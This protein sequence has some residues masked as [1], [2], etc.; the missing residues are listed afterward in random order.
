MIAILLLALIACTGSPAA[1][2]PSTTP[3][4]PPPT[5]SPVKPATGSPTREPVVWLAPMAAPAGAADFMDLFN[6]TA[7][8]EQAAGHVQVFQLSGEWVAQNATDDELRRIVADLERRGLV[9]AL[10]AR[11][12]VQTNRC[13]KGREGFAGPAERLRMLRRL[14]AAG[15]TGRLV[16]F[17]VLDAPYAFGHNDEGRAACG[18]S[19]RRIA[20]QVAAYLTTTRH[21]FSDVQVGDVEP[22]GLD[23][24]IKDLESW[25]KTYEKV[26]G[27][28]LAFFHLAVDAT[29]SGWSEKATEMEKFCRARGIPFGIVYMGRGPT[30]QAW[31]TSAEE[32]FVSF[33]A[34]AG[35]RPDD[36]VFQA[37]PGRP[38]HVLPES[39]SGTLTHLID[40]YFRTRTALD[41]ELGPSEYVGSLRASGTLM[42]ASGKPIPKA[43]IR[44]TLTPVDHPGSTTFDLGT[45]VTDGRGYF[46]LTFH[47]PGVFI[48]LGT[49]VVQAWFPGDD[50]RWPA[51]AGGSIQD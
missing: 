11:P 8:W 25:I 15:A 24:K 29:R 45:R 48:H 37:S 49:V 6:E 7:S 16:R 12:L 41:M 35:G 27:S 14:E 44:L 23:T 36:V 42:D 13:G 19:S 39:Q 46:R 30:D 38:E 1:K 47:P 51:Y 17:V 10:E 34:K 21:T 32:R 28:E 43:I 26:T 22:F 5:T 4:A 3:N 33:E 40:R 31:S 18:W 50:R 2:G 9:V 20:Q